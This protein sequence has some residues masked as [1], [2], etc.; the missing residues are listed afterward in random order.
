VNPGVEI[1]KSTG[2]ECQAVCGGSNS[3]SEVLVCVSAACWA[4]IIESGASGHYPSTLVLGSWL[5]CM[6]ILLSQC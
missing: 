1:V 2:N 4:I 5:Y 3:I 6:L